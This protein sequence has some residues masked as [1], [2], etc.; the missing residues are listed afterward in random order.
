MESNV[1]LIDKDKELLLIL[2][3]QVVC[4]FDVVNIKRKECK[5]I[6]GEF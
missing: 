6:Y 1:Y 3:W 4:R 2:K 5:K